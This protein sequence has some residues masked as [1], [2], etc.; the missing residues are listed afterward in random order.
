MTTAP[1]ASDEKEIE[2]GAESWTSERLEEA[3]DSYLAEH[4]RLLLDPEARNIR[5][6]RITPA[7]DNRVWRVEQVLVD[8]EAKND[9]AA[10]FDVDLERSRATGEPELRLRRLASLL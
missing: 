6:T 10:E 4:E 1:P 3:M 2:S 5:H 8:P 7:D 9:W